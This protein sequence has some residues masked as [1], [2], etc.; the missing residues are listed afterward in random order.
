MKRTFR[1]FADSRR[2]PSSNA[3]I[4]RHLQILRKELKIPRQRPDAMCFEKIDPQVAG[5]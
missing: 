5:G 2:Y 1:T 3:K 4:R